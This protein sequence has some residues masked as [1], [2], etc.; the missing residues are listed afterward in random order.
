[1]SRPWCMIG[2]HGLM[3]AI[4]AMKECIAEG[5]GDKMKTLIERNIK[6]SLSVNEEALWQTYKD[7]LDPRLNQ[8]LPQGKE[9]W[10]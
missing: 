2:V 3:N 1:M 5:E 8:D 6:N 9:V 10:R 4:A 7:F